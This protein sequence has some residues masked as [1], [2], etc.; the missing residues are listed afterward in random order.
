MFNP[1][2]HAIVFEGGFAEVGTFY[3]IP[4][5]AL[6]QRS[7]LSISRATKPLE[8]G[9][10]LQSVVV[11]KD[12]PMGSV[13]SDFLLRAIHS[14]I[15]ARDSYKAIADKIDV[16]EGKR[17]MLAMSVEEDGH[18]EIL[19]NRYLSLTGSAYEYDSSTVIGTS[20][21]FIE[22][23]SF[24]YTGAA[25]ALSLCLSAEI[26]AE[27]FYCRATDEVTEPEDLKMIRSLIRFERKHIR[28]LLRAISRL[29]R[30]NK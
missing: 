24:S 12:G 22:K 5:T 27:S 8:F 30:R 3:Y 21:D 7:A 23:S 4:L 15:A 16:S 11:D 14:E 26:D 9:L 29:K 19:A 10:Q 6:P 25:D 20:F 13:G 28:K 1:H 2:F 17:V 18:R